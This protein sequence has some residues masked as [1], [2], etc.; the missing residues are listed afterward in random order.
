MDRVSKMWAS[1]ALSLMLVAC[2][3]TANKPDHNGNPQIM[4]LQSQAEAAYKM[5]KLDQAESQ[6]LQVLQSV[7]NYAPAWFRLGNIYTRTGRHD[8][9]IAAYQRC[10][11]LEP[12]NQKAWYNMGLVRLKQSTEILE[13]IE[14]RGDKESPVGRQISALLDALNQLQREPGADTQVGMQ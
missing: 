10:I 1:V 2:S 13:S 6:Y 3:S 12:D 9:A 14:R 4:A 5:A 11:E 8:A 7:P